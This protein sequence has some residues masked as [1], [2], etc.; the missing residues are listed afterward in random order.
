VVDDEF[1]NDFQRHFDGLGFCEAKNWQTSF[2][3]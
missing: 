1:V 2:C 3:R